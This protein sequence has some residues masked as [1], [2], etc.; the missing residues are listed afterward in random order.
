MFDIIGVFLHGGVQR[1]ILATKD[2]FPDT[3][4]ESWKTTT[5]EE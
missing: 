4:S 3:D 2:S 5:T 1:A